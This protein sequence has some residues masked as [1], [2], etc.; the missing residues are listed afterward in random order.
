MDLYFVVIVV[1]VGMGDGQL[2]M[3]SVLYVE[4]KRGYD[5]E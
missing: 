4:Y 3:E 2:V 5:N 1:V